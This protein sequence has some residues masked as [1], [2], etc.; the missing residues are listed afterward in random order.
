MKTNPLRLT[1]VMP[2]IL[3][4]VS[5]AQPANKTSTYSY[6]GG[7]PTPA[8]VQTAK[9]EG[10][11]GRAVT[12]YRF[13]YPAV[14]LAGIFNGMAFCADGAPPWHGLE[15]RSSPR[16]PT[17]T[18]RRHLPS[19]DPAAYPTLHPPYLPPPPLWSASSA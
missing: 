8:T 9:D 2:A 1:L 11:L 13:W 19:V 14:S 10:D 4:L 12:A 16:R 18:S 3:G 7:Y 15:A 17:R 6:Q 5:C